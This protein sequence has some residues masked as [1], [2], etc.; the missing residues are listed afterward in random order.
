MWGGGTL[1]PHSIA[2]RIH[3]Q[4]YKTVRT[5][6]E[7]EEYIGNAEVVAFSFTI[8]SLLITQILLYQFDFLTLILVCS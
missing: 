6:A 3:M 1:P 2:R 5:V 8:I 7:I 4:E